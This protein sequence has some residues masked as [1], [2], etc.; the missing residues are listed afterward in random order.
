MKRDMPR[1][2]YFSSFLKGPLAYARC[3]SF[4]AQKIEK[5]Q[6]SVADVEETNVLILPPHELLFVES[7]VGVKKNVQKGVGILSSIDASLDCP[8]EF[9]SSVSDRTR[10]NGNISGR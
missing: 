3:K 10:T 1:M 6:S 4:L 7:L 8:A 9:S 2:E 5:P